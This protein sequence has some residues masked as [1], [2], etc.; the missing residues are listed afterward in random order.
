[1]FWTW[2]RASRTV[3]RADA[4]RLGFDNIGFWQ[5]FFDDKRPVG[6][7]A[8]GPFAKGG[9]LPWSGARDFGRLSSIRFRNGVATSL[10]KH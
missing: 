8:G 7:P 10:N 3:C 5:P 9:E 6:K 4:E 2:P 1:M